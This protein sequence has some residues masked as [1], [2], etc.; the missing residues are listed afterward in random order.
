[1]GFGMTT[2]RIKAKKHKELRPKRKGK[3]KAKTNIENKA[4]ERRRRSG[5]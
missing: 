1:M 3:N 2:L 5:L 4:T